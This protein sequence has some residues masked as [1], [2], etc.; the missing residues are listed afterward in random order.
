M[1]LIPYI[2]FHTHPFR[3]E[4]DTV[5]VQ[6]IYP[7]DGFAAFTGRNFYSVG[8]HPWHIGSEKENNV[9][10][11][12]VEEALEFD[13]VIFVGEAGLDKLAN[14][15]FNEQ[16]R[17]FEAQAFI[18]EEYKY[19]LVIHCVK[20]LNEVIQLRKK[21]SPVMPWI[22]HAYNGG[23]E[24]TKQLA[25]MNFMFSFGESLFRSNS[26]GIESFK[27]ID[28]DKLFFETD[29]QEMDVETVYKQGAKLK[30]ISIEQ[31][32]AAIWNNFNR[33]EKSLS[34]N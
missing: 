17:V 26:K 8:L 5:I 34:S 19:P 23:I 7:G 1:N 16:K 24:I 13:H 20:A 6:N 33:I 22:L 11:Q 3:N 15:D 4:K 27:Y 21:M 18:A 9:A 29:E 2:D 31:L 32:K 12:M 10:L 25:N 30:E 14:T 28:L